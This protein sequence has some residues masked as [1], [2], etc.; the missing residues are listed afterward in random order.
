MNDYK[1]Q[2]ASTAR[3]STLFGVVIAVLAHM[4]LLVYG[5]F[6]GI[7]YLYPP[8]EEQSFLIDFSEQEPRPIV[9]QRRGTEPTMEEIDPTKPLELVQRSESPIQGK[10]A[11]KAPEAQIDD[12]G[13]VE[14]PDPPKEKEIDRRALFRAADNETDKDTLAPQTAGRK[15]SVTHPDSSSIAARVNAVSY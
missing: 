13:D 12:H 8:P 11:N 15:G 10:K 5:V 6:S 3:S 9:Q 2:R 1:Q 4:F 7:K 14:V